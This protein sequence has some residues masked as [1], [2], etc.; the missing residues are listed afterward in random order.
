MKMDKK[1]GIII[2]I[3]AILIFIAFIYGMFFRCNIPLKNMNVTGGMNNSYEID[4]GSSGTVMY[5]PYL[6]LRKGKYNINVKYEADSS[7]YMRVTVFKGGGV[8]GE[9]ELPADK[10]SANIK[11]ELPCDMYDS[12]VEFVVD[13]HGKGHLR[14]DSL[15][16]SNSRIYFGE[17]LLL[18]LFVVI[19]LCFVRISK[20]ENKEWYLC[21]YIIM[22]LLTGT[23]MA[24]NILFM[25][26][27]QLAVLYFAVFDKKLLLNREN[28]VLY[29]AITAFAFAL[30]MICTK[31]SPLYLL[32]DWVDTQSY[33]T[34]GKGIFNGK[35]IYKDLFEQKGPLFYLMY[36]IGYLINTHNLHGAY[37]IEGLLSALT[38]I[39]AYK[40]S[41]LYLSKN[42]SLLCVCLLPVIIYNGSFMRYGGTCEEFMTPFIMMSFYYFLLIFKENKY[43]SKYMF[44]NGALGGIILMMKFNV[45]MFFVGLGACV[46]VMYLVRKDYNRL[47]ENLVATV[48]G[49]F[50]IIVPVFIWL[51][52]SGSIGGFFEVIAFNS[53]YS[54]IRLDI[55]GIHKTIRNIINSWNGNWFCTAVMV[56]GLS[57]FAFTR[58]FINR[59]GALG[60]VLSFLLINYGAFASSSQAYY[61]MAFCAFTVFGI[62]SAVY[63]I[64]EMNINV[65]QSVVAALAVLSVAVTAHYNNN[66][67]ET[68]P[69][70]EYVSAQDKFAMIMRSKTDEPTLLNY[71]FLDG[72]FYTAADIVP[73]VRFFQK[74]NISDYDYPLNIQTQ[75]SA[76]ENKDVQFVV[77]RRNSDSG[78]DSTPALVNNYDLVAQH[79]QRFEGCDFTYYLYE[80][81]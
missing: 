35:A 27:L 12:G 71:N 42:L 4:N 1:Q 46:F 15:T 41:R 13:Y 39:F 48:L 51:A 32:N 22:T 7:N 72:G 16:L 6:S 67:K 61:Y 5:G 44:I 47:I 68:R 10:T 23:V 2:I 14:I 58:K 65:K 76:M 38:F 69:F 26:I 31:S 28:A 75:I 20:V 54:P 56:L 66:Y 55:D 24:E 34:M 81:K 17:I 59:W 50:T 19:S 25:L 36:G 37:F 70:I 77:V 8:V 73:N 78:S 43:E 40:I 53:K 80:A 52:I 33:Y 21:F 79:Q 45:T 9:G 29:T 74:Q 3:G 63:I 60:L 62:I 11:F 18:I 57:S 64:K 49:A 30:M